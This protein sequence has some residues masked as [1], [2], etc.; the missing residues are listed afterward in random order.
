MS[1]Y[2][3][4]ARVQ[5]DPRLVPFDGIASSW[6]VNKNGYRV[7]PGAFCRTIKAAKANRK[8]LNGV[9]L[10]PILADHKPELAYGWVATAQETEDGLYV[11]GYLDPTTPETRD[12]LQGAKKGYAN[13]MSIGFKVLREHQEGRVRVVDEAEIFEI[14]TG[15]IPVD[16]N[17]RIHIKS[18][19]AVE[20]A[21]LR[22]IVQEKE[23]KMSFDYDERDDY[24]EKPLLPSPDGLTDFQRAWR[25][26]IGEPKAY[27]VEPGLEEESF[28]A[29]ERAWRAELREEDDAWLLTDKN[30]IKEWQ[31]REKARQDKQKKQHEALLAERRQAA[32]RTTAWNRETFTP[33]DFAWLTGIDVNWCRTIFQQYVSS[34]LVT[35]VE[36]GTL[37]LSRSAV[38]L[39][40]RR[41]AEAI[42][43]QVIKARNKR[44]QE[45]Q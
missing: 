12:A 30:R 26:Q 16:D 27:C 34:G 32:E 28:A 40:G 17:A 33:E 18:F 11:A 5:H 31:R 10:W 6:H 19:S 37:K 39:I 29:F 44:M 3:H 9:L 1:N 20:D 2:T 7:S 45:G 25:G 23:S 4:D 21:I 38:Q 15:A 41:S 43:F 35:P 14:S 22:A 42:E 24:G 36:E 13:G 8:R